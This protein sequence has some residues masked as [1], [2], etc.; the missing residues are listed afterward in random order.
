M[1]DVKP[2]PVLERARIRMSIAGI[3]ATV[4]RQR[5]EMEEMKDRKARNEENIAASLKAIAELE[6]KLAA[7]GGG[8]E[9]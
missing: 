4:E 8:K 3:N 1:G 5:F 9:D 6:E 2:N 7:M